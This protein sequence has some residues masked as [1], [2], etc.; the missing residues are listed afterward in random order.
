MTTGTTDRL[1]GLMCTGTCRSL[2][3]FGAEVH[4]YTAL[5]FTTYKQIMG[6]RS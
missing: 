5:T 2:R 3:S 4:I 6:S 1:P